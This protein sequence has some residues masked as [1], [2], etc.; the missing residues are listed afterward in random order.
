MQPSG[1]KHNATKVCPFES[2]CDF[3][4]DGDIDIDDNNATDWDQCAYSEAIT[5]SPGDLSLWFIYSKNANDHNNVVGHTEEQDNGAG[6][7]GF[8]TSNLKQ[9]ARVL[10]YD[11]SGESCTSSISIMPSPS[12]LYYCEGGYDLANKHDGLVL[13]LD[14]TYVDLIPVVLIS[15]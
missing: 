10:I 2:G 8:I 4:G 1:C 7:I 12:T 3:D 15:H 11:D 9:G 13:H 6:N 5:I 14:Q